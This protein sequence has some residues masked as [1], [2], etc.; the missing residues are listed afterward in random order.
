MTP[1]HAVFLS[2]ALHADH[3][4]AGPVS[5]ADGVPITV[6]MLGVRALHD[7]E[8]ESHAPARVAGKH[9]VFGQVVDG[10]PVIKAA[11]ACGSGGGNTSFDVMIK[12]CGQVPKGS[13]R[14]AAAAGDR[15]RSSTWVVQAGSRWRIVGGSQSRAHGA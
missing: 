10:Y 14:G 5:P 4:S 15:R 13:E 11:E 2:A 6:K 8:V 3:G 1:A 7:F 12:D 9:V